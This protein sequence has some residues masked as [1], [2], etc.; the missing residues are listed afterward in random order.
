MF[1]L[2]AIV[3]AA[4]EDHV[5]VNPYEGSYDGWLT[6]TFWTMNQP[7]QTTFD[8]PDTFTVD[9]VDDTMLRV[10]GGS[11]FKLGADGTFSQHSSGSTYYMVRF[12]E[13]DS[14][15]VT[16]S[17]GGL[18]GGSVSNFRGRKNP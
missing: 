12:V 6:S 2:A 1:I 3:L 17:N 7:L 18:G 5:P 13:P 16:D 11:P 10:N 15:M 8:G 9:V 14:L 4:C